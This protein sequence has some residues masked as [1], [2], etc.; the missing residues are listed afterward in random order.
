LFASVR[1]A[2]EHP[3]EIELALWFHDAI[4]DPRAAD[5]ER[6]SAEM[7]V[8]MLADTSVSR[9]SIDRVASMILATT[10]A[11]VSDDPD[12]RLC[13]DIDLAILGAVPARFDEYERQVREEYHW[14]P[15]VLYRHRRAALLSSFLARPQLY[16]TAAV[17]ERL[18]SAARANLERSLAALGS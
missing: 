18:E 17:R 8:A 16:A 5:N 3:E 1:D 9:A 15:L 12:T 11:T 7:A 13:C 10:H 14:V 2:A 4:Y 6:R